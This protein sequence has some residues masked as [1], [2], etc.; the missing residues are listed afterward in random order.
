MKDELASELISVNV[1][2]IKDVFRSNCS[3]TPVV[4][5]Y[6]IGEAK[7][8]LKDKNYEDNEILVK[9]GCTE[10]IERRCGELDRIY[11]KEF[12]KK[13]ELLCFSIIEA[14]YI[15]NAESSISQYFKSNLINYKNYKELIVIDKKDINQIKQHYKMIQCSY[16][17]RYDE[18]YNK[19]QILEKEI[20]DLNN[21]LLM[22]DKDIEIIK[23]I[24]ENEIQL[25]DIELL[26]YKIKNLENLSNN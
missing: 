25:K 3:K 18:M 8:L 7:E 20:I 22:K 13:I 1:K 4:Y 17:G 14:K 15:H 12:N 11:T 26:K 24:H 5:L 2:T 23:K 21:K 16:I 6:L 19:I 10:D 9:F